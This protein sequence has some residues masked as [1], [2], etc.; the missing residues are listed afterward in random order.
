MST[1]PRRPARP[2][3]HHRPV[4]LQ[5]LWIMRSPVFVRNFDAILR[6]LVARGHHVH[7]AFEGDKHGY[8]DD[9]RSLISELA[10]AHAQITVGLAAAPGWSRSLLRS[11]L[12]GTADYLHYFE[13]EYVHAGALRA[14][15]RHHA[16][17]GIGMFAPAL[18]R[19]SR[20]RRRLSSAATALANAA[21]PPRR[22]M[23]FLRAHSAD[24][25]LVSPLTHFDSPQPD[26][27]R[28]ARR[29]GLPSGLV[30]FSWDNLTNKGLMHAVP[31]RVLVWNEIQAREAAR[32]HGVASNRIEVTG[33]A[34]Y[35]HW[36]SWQPS[37]DR[38]RFLSELGLDPRQPCVLYVCS[39][40]FIARDESTWVK[41]WIDALRATSGP[42]SRV[43]IIVR[44]HPLN[45]DGW[46]G[47]PLGPVPA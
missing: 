10:A 46:R 31:D 6:A 45:I 27:L 25:L 39:S 37:R 14:R 33:A 38:E 17:P 36:F 12:R 13:P 43:N 34:A 11:R 22:I 15:A 32:H 42:L 21:P 28:A 20:L 41:H 23:R 1:T 2:E 35:D 44:P 30:L 26:Y 7:V 3:P 5:I 9:Q 29:R 47:D 16:L 19:R 4:T 8:H 18:R 24:V 40:G